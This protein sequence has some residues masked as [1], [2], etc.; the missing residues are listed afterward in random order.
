MHMT[1]HLARMQLWSTASVLPIGVVGDKAR[2]GLTSL[3]C[4]VFLARKA[5]DPALGSS[6]VLMLCCDA[7]VCCEE[8]TPP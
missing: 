6:C 5:E 8:H 2:N 7:M 1:S 4:D 3:K